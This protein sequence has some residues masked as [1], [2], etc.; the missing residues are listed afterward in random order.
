[1]ERSL[2]DLAADVMASRIGPCLAGALLAVGACGDDAAAPRPA[3]LTVLA[4]SADFAAFRHPES[5]D[6]KY[7]APV[8]GR[9]AVPP[10]TAACYFQ[11]MNLTPWHLQFLQ[12]FPQLAA[13]DYDEY[14]N[15]VMRGGSR[16]LWAGTLK[17]WPDALHPLTR[18]PGVLS[19]EIYG[20]PGSVDAAAIREV[21][22]A[23][24]SCVPYA[25]QQL[26]FVAVTEDQS[27]V[28]LGQRKQLA[29]QGI[30]TVLREELV[31]F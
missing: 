27:V 2:L 21:D 25:R 5:G 22:A 20:E 4:T 9:P 13:L 30:A 6:L 26:A 18:A 7:L 10:L 14:L 17:P 8:D 28:V 11:D 3:F 12:S 1:M 29:A 15:L 23:L 31:K 16:R 24:K 19:Y